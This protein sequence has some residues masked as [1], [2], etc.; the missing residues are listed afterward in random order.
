MTYIISTDKGFK[1]LKEL[2]EKKNVI[3]DALNEEDLVTGLLAFSNTTNT[4][5]VIARWGNGFIWNSRYDGKGVNCSFQPKIH[6][7]RTLTNSEY[8][9]VRQQAIESAP[10]IKNEEV[11]K[12]LVLKAASFGQTILDKK[13]AW[14]YYVKQDTPYQVDLSGYDVSE[15]EKEEIPCPEGLAECEVYHYRMVVTLTPK[16]VENSA[17]SFTEGSELPVAAPL[18]APTWYTKNEIYDYLIREN[19]SKNIAE[20]LAGTWSD[21]LQ[22]AFNKGFEK[23]MR[24]LSSPLPSEKETK[25]KDID[26]I[27]WYSGM[28]KEQIESAF[29]RYTKEVLTRK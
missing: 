3:S 25:I 15:P 5:G 17:H 27:L 10:F 1:L 21:Q 22:G 19:Y 13:K 6:T 7:Y 2:P 8:N 29:K 4:I 26:F 12:E 14:K 16:V 24:S 28:K 11:A 23:G 18:E 20:E 9:Q